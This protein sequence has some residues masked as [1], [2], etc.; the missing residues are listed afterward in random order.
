MTDRQCVLGDVLTLQRG[1]DLPSQDRK[2]GKVPIISSSGWTG[3][4][5]EGR[6]NAPGVVIGRYGTLGM[7]HFVEEQFWPLNTTLYVKDFKGNDPRYC[8]YLL[9]TI[10]AVSSSSASAVPG[11]N[12]N[13]LHGLPVRHV[14]LL[15]QRRIA[16]ILGAYDDLIQVNER[17]M[18]L[19]E[20]M[21]RGLFEEWFV[22]FR[23][24]GH[25]EV[26]M[27]KGPEGALPTGWRMVPM[28]DVADVNARSLRA[29]SAPE[30]IGYIDIASVSPGQV[31]NI[32]WM[33]LADA[34]SRARRYVR[35]GSILWSTVRPNRRSFAYL[36]DPAEG[37]V[38]ST[39]FTVIDTTSVP[40]AYL[41]SFVTTDA[42][43]AYLVGRA[44]G[45]AY[46]AVT[47]S[48]FSGAPVIVPPK[49]LL[50]AFDALAAPSL[51]MAASL[52]SANVL[53]AA[54]RD[55]LLPRLISGQ[56]SVTDAE[57]E[58]QEAA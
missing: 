55:L 31:D 53:L 49:D 46:P 37:V 26:A 12:R 44:T 41:Y 50:A 6:I 33:E 21:A 27:V 25:E 8:A 52:R 23:F 4:H 15:E 38:A 24:P 35:D 56:L 19:L 11:V 47:A 14:P 3:T 7:V 30:H 34:P 45:A 42:F 36:I 58:L 29:N 22:R 5:S 10:G 28:V 20:D 17:R 39:G 1:F 54:T 32:T 2:P 18:A 43:V 48:V 57:R 13:V 9:T 51:R 40:S 16:S